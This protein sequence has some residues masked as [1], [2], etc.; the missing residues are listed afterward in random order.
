MGDFIKYLFLLTLFGGGGYLLYQNPEIL[1]RLQL[2]SITNEVAPVKLA[3]AQPEIS[4]TA[5]YVPPA[6]ITPE[7]TLPKQ[8]P[9]PAPQT[10]AVTPP[11]PEPAKPDP[12]IAAAREREEKRRAAAARKEA[13]L[14]NPPWEIATK[15]GRVYTG[16][17]ISSVLP[18]G[19]MIKHD[20][21]GC[22]VL[23]SEMTSDLQLAFGYD[24]DEAAAQLKEKGS[25]TAQ[26]PTP[27][28]R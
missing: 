21:G 25:T 19:I 27:S 20:M 22:R 7:S 12:A 18:D 3:P 14:K 24:K 4:R 28:L 5:V 13:T 9:A 10:V 26:N 16:V 6:V 1:Q 8:A 23:Y 11:A 15:S 17:K 2:T